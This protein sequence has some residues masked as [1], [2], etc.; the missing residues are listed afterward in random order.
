M[1]SRALGCVICVEC[2]RIPKRR[3]RGVK[4]ETG[5]PDGTKTFMMAILI[6]AGLWTHLKFGRST[7]SRKTTISHWTHTW[8]CMTMPFFRNPAKLRMKLSFSISISRANTAC[9]PV[10][11]CTTSGVSTTSM[12]LC[13][14]AGKNRKN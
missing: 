9:S 12:V 10:M 7:S 14:N 13:W 4:R 8:I 11:T 1:R 5:V 3:R 6:A 2:T